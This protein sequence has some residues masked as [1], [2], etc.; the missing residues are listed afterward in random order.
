MEMTRAYEKLATASMNGC[1][2]SKE[3]ISDNVIHWESRA[4]RRTLQTEYIRGKTVEINERDCRLFADL[5]RK[6]LNMS[7]ITIS[8]MI[9][10]GDYLPPIVST[11]A[12]THNIGIHPSASE[13]SGMNLGAGFIGAYPN[14]AIEEGSIDSKLAKLDG[15]IDPISKG[16]IKADDPSSWP[17]WLQRDMAD[18]TMVNTPESAECPNCSSEDG[19]GTDE[20][21]GEVYC[22]SCGWI[23]GTGP[24]DEDYDIDEFEDDTMP[25]WTA[26]DHSLFELRLRHKGLM[27]FK[28]GGGVTDETHTEWSEPESKRQP[29]EVIQT[30]HWVKSG[31]V[32]KYQCPI[33]GEL[34]E[35]QV[36]EID[37]E[38]KIHF[39]V[40]GVDPISI[41][42]RKIFHARRGLDKHLETCDKFC[43][44]CNRG[45]RRI[46]GLIKRKLQLTRTN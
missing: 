9:A 10:T 45:D 27:P 37:P 42:D 1:K 36:L 24:L 30:G 39:I 34:K 7:R 19:F 35:E 44:E 3:K 40:T 5:W 6:I 25:E 17:T 32:V 8:G 22:L 23:V 12:R 20:Y 21:K 46:N 33:T 29:P 38:Q 15:T 14:T 31:R 43:P 11:L 41:M 28:K 4:N 2:R 26:E 13:A 18:M 16:F